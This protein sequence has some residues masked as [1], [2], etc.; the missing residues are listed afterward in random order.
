MK[1]AIV[2]DSK[3]AAEILRRIL[4][5]LPDFT[6]AWIAY[7]GEEALRLCAEA[8]P[9]IILM[10]LIMPGIDGAETTRRIMQTTPCV[11]LVVTATT[12]GNRDMVF[13]AMGYGALDAVNT[14]VLGPGENLDGAEPLIQKLRMVSRLVD[15]HHAKLGHARQKAAG[16][17]TSGLPIVAI[18][19]STGGPQALAQILSQLPANFPAA[20]LVV[21]HVDEQ[22]TPGLASWLR[23]ASSLPVCIARGGETLHTAGVWIAG[24]SDNLIYDSGRLIYIAPN[25]DSIHRPSID[26]LFMSLARPHRATRIGVLLTGMGRD[27]A[28]GLL[29]MRKSGALTI[30]QD[31]ATSVVY[32]MPKAAVEMNAAREVMPLASIAT[33]ICEAVLHPAPS[34]L[35][36]ARNENKKEHTSP[37]SAPAIR[38]KEPERS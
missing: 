6:L 28:A 5:G 32:G 30:A 8:K 3:M 16:P 20:V 11:I 9:D 27:G 7:S 37:V 1:V 35:G 34:F 23:H 19:S 17:D 4:A 22:F 15:S 12:V 36:H 25:K 10:D 2:N 26:A 29:A 33:R 24:T 31:A 13:E 18:G 14:P 21:Q 38:S